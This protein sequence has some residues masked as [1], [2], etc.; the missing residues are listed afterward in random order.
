M[1]VPIEKIVLTRKGADLGSLVPLDDKVLA[2]QQGLADAFFKLKIVPKQLD[3]KSAFWTTHRPTSRRHAQ[4]GRDEPGCRYS[5][6]I[7]SRSRPASR[8]QVG[9][10]RGST[11]L[12]PF[13]VPVGLIVRL[14]GGLQPR[15]DH[16]TG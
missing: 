12:L 10:G 15:A 14:A 6:P 4:G 1:P 3:I 2:Y 16:A 9:A 5:K 13:A 7:R 8:P 11:G